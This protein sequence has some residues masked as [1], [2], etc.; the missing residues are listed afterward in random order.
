MMA[1]FDFSIIYIGSCGKLIVAW[2]PS[3]CHKK[4]L[5]GYWIQELTSF[6]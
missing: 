4:R 3:T 6:M 2:L 5:I 1:S